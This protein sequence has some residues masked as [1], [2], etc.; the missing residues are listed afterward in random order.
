[1]YE[2]HTVT[3]GKWILAGEHAVLRGHQAVIFPVKAKT[4]KVS[5]QP[6]KEQIQAEFSGEYAQEMRMLFWGAY[7]HALK[8]LNINYND[9][10]GKFCVENN[11]P[12]GTGMGGSAALC[13]ALGRFFLEQK[14]IAAENLLEF[15]RQVENLFHIESS[16]AD[17]AVTIAGAPIL[18]SRHSDTAVF[19]PIWSPQWY[20]S[21]SGVVS[22]TAHCVQKVK[23]LFIHDKVKAETLDRRMAES[24]ALA[25][26]ALQQP[27]ELGFNI[28]MTAINEACFCFRQWGLVEGAIN[29]HINDLIAG[30]A[31][32]AKPTGSGN[33]GYVLSLWENTPPKNWLDKMIAV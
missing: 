6:G 12:I 1:M 4:L 8:L 24:T 14:F 11:V 23:D 2:F 30:G 29:Q 31:L 13:V 20:L 15:S 18:F 32:A 5:F 19:E 33:G 22:S 16:G 27:I 9:I 7:E 21:F 26:N 10:R 17:I 28:L 3:N 25:L